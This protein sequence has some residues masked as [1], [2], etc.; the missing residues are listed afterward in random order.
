MALQNKLRVIIHSIR[1]LCL[2]LLLINFTC[3]R[4]SSSSCMC[5]ICVH[6]AHPHPDV[7]MCAIYCTSKF[8]VVL[9]RCPSVIFC[10][11]RV[12]SCPRFTIPLETTSVGSQLS[13][14]IKWGSLTIT[15]LLGVEPPVI[16]PA[17][18]TSI[19]DQSGEVGHMHARV[20]MMAETT[21][22]VL[23]RQLLREKYKMCIHKP[24]TL[25]EVNWTILV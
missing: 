23:V 12:I 3:G 11:L 25:I 5:N 14:I 4:S 21:H 7:Y 2:L 1:L 6:I 8:T 20:A 18:I 15:Q 16:G 22:K 24:A 10:I 9:A 13:T 17:P 19:W